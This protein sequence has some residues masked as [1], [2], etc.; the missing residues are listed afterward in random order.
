MLATTDI[1]PDRRFRSPLTEIRYPCSR[2]ANDPFFPFGSS[3]LVPFD[4][5]TTTD[6]SCLVTPLPGM[7]KATLPFT[8][9]EDGDTDVFSAPPNG[10]SVMIVDNKGGTCTLRLFNSGGQELDTV[11]W[12][13]GDAADQELD[14]TGAKSVYVFDDNCIIRLSA[15][16]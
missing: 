1:L 6:R 12:Q 14:T 11:Q 3:T 5:W 13:P 16:S 4:T 15:Q 2:S 7:G 10:L 9:E 8:Q